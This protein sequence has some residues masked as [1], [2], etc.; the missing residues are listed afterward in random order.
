MK[1]G[2]RSKV[3]RRIAALVLLGLFLLDQLHFS[4]HHAAVDCLDHVVD[5]QECDGDRC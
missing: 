3:R 4:N 2:R 1:D 5:G